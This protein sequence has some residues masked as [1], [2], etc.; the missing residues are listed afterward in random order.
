SPAVSRSSSAGLMPGVGPAAVLAVKGG[1][2]HT[3]AFDPDRMHL[4]SFNSDEA[5]AEV[6]PAGAP[7]SAAAAAAAAM[8][9]GMGGASA[10]SGGFD[11]GLSTTDV[12]VEW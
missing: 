2:E 4:G 3:P 5:F 6:G 10:W 1:D 11:G 8:G 9:M 12:V 7:A